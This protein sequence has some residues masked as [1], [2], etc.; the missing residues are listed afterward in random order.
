MAEVNNDNAVLFA[1]YISLYVNDMACNSICD[2]KKF[3]NRKDKKTLKRWRELDTINRHYFTHIRKVVK[4]QGSYFLSNFNSVL[5]EEADK[6]VEQLFT[7]IRYCLKRHS[8]DD[9][10][11]ICHTMI[12]HILSEL[13]VSV[14]QSLCDRLKEDGIPY[15]GLLSWRIT[16]IQMAVREVYYRVCRDIDNAILKEITSMVTPIVSLLTSKISHYKTF[17]KAYEYAIEEEREYY[18]RNKPD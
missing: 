6:P 3:L 12:S 7:A 5:D 4:L 14:V 17:E 18:E 8:I 9:N 16:K 10:G 15:K 11:L 13:A 1:T 2:I